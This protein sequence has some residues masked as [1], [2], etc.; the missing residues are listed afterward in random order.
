MPHDPNIVPESSY[1]PLEVPQFRSQIPEHLLQG[2]NASDHFILEQLSILT[3]SAEWSNRAHVST[4]ESVRK[5]N[6][7]LIRAEDEIKSLKEDRKS[8]KVG[9]KV[10]VTI[11]SVTAGVL[12]LGATIYQAIKGG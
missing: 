3:Q 11:V 5:T 6:G 12:T 2:A 7:R 1:P 4:M 9:W 8:I 10:I